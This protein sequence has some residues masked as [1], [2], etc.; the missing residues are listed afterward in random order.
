MRV[1]IIGCGYVGPPLGTE[2]AA[3]GIKPLAA[4]HHRAL[5]LVGKP[6]AHD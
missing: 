2:L 4:F 1:L 3:A 5:L 6:S